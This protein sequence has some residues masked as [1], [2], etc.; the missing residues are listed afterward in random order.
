MKHRLVRSLI[1][2]LALVGLLAPSVALAQSSTTTAKK[3]TTTA[4]K[5]AK[6]AKLLDLNTAPKADLVKLPGI[7]DAIAQKIIEGRPYQSKD[8]LVSKNIVTQAVYDKFK[9]NVIAKQPTTSKK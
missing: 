2:A 8:Q 9:D 4:A 6:P 5:P 3:T 7:G 1:L